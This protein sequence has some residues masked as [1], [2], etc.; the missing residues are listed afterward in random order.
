MREDEMTD[1]DV[2]LHREGRDGE[3]GGVRRRLGRHRTHHAERLAEHP[4]V[5][6]PERVGLLRQTEQQ[7]QKVG[8]GQVKQVVV[9]HR[10]HVLGASDHETRAHVTDDASHE[11]HAIYDGHRY[12]LVESF[13]SRSQ[14]LRQVERRITGNTSG[15]T[16]C[17][18][19]TAVGYDI[20]E[21]VR[22]VHVR[23]LM[24]FVVSR[25]IHGRRRQIRDVLWAN[26]T[27]TCHGQDPTPFQLQR[28]KHV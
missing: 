11:Y 28:K 23:H 13:P 3:D 22:N 19:S 8:H 15:D 4:R 21:Y 1:S 5:G 24:Q 6:R 7:H 2:A 20:V 16:R 27:H 18:T 10:L 9:R 14:D 26:V 25:D 12:D 17:D